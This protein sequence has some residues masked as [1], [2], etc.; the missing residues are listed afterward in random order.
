MTSDIEEGH[1][2][3]RRVVYLEGNDNYKDW[4]TS[5]EIT[6]IQKDLIDVADGSEP[7]PADESTTLK[8]W[9]R[10]DRKAWGYIV[11]SLSPTVRGAL[12]ARFTKYSGSTNASSYLLLEHLRNTYSAVR[13]AR[14]AELYH[15]IWA[16]KLDEG[17]D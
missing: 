3:R 17:A 13:G 10:Q 5:I 7:R 12:P 2:S 1:T 8:A 15:T 4:D 11:D 6:L 16:S 14:M 9:R